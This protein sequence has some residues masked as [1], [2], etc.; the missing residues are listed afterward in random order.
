MTESPESSAAAVTL[1]AHTGTQTEPHDEV[2]LDQFSAKVDPWMMILALAWLPVLIVPLITT[3]HGSIATAF[4]VF[5]YLVWAA[6][7]VE[8]VVKLRLAVDRGRFFRH[9]LLDL[10]VVAVPI[11]RPLR[12]A[13]LFRVVRLERVI[14]VLGNGLR[15]A[16]SLLTHHGL[17]FV[18]LAVT[19]IVFAAAALESVLER[20]APGSTIHNYGDGLWWAIVTVTTVGYGDKVPVTGGGKFVAV[21]LMLTGIGL[22]GFLTASVASFF[23]Q[24]QNTNELDEVTA[25]LDQVLTLLGEVK[26]EKSV[27]ASD[28]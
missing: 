12:L 18:L 8:Y 5:D 11:L 14:L 6:F 25:K 24:Q 3:L 19:V 22:V 13:Q 9:H 27:E 2:R 23:V 28:G 20:H 21:A 17:H 4:D 15:R 7:G 10:A 26:L 1:P 16:K